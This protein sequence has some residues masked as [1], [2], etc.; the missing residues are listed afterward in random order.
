MLAHVLILSN[1]KPRAHSG[2]WT[3]G[4]P[5]SQKVSI[6][7]WRTYFLALASA[8]H[9]NASKLYRALQLLLLLSPKLFPI[10]FCQHFPL[11]NPRRK[12]KILACSWEVLGWNGAGR[13]S[14]RDSWPADWFCPPHSHRCEPSLC[15]VGGWGEGERWTGR[16]EGT[17][18]DRKSLP[19]SRVINDP[20]LGELTTAKGREGSIHAV[21]SCAKNL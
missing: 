21:G 8:R 15:C 4:S 1:M 3:F 7:S 20:G 10:S 14:G 18:A 19:G 6:T 5:D 9:Q 13:G 16:S 12:L 11:A 2:S 17:T